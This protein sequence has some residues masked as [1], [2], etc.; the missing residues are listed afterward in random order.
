MRKLEL[1]AELTSS[2]KHAALGCPRTLN[3]SRNLDLTTSHD[4]HLDCPTKHAS[5]IQVVRI[6][7][8]PLHVLGAHPVQTVGHMH[9]AAVNDKQTTGNCVRVSAVRE[10]GYIQRCGHR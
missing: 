1:T 10:Q 9:K 7:S 6:W 8:R 3:G 5:F 4:I 2:G